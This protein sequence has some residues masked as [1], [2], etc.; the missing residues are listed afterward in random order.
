MI[1][2]TR[3]RLYLSGTVF[4][5]LLALAY[6]TLTPVATDCH[7]FRQE[8]AGAAKL[9]AEQ[10]AL[11]LDFLGSELPKKHKNLFHKI[12]ESEFR[13]RVEALKAKLPSLS[14][15]EILAGLMRI[16]AAVGDS[17]TTIGYRSQQ[18][19][20]L[21]L[22]WFKDGISVLNTTA[23]YRDILFGK[24]TAIG[25]KSIEDVVPVLAPLIPHETPRSF[26][27]Q[28]SWPLRTRLP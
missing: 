17:H 25:G 24:I 10:W 5:A 28:E 7:P 8:A 19:L 4:I 9:T 11:D 13:A 20:P 23:E 22:Y 12:S 18:G 21:M 26:M 2:P 6:S 14:Q 27:V 1:Q 15:D 16:V 3:C